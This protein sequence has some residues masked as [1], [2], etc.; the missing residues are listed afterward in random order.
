MIEFTLY[1]ED[2]EG[3]RRIAVVPSQIVYYA[4]VAKR[5]LD[6]S[7]TQCTKITLVTGES[8]VVTACYDDVK[9]RLRD[10]SL[11][12]RDAPLPEPEPSRASEGV[13]CRGSE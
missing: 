10:Y 2:R 4:A 7:W 8:F 3:D 1:Q 11:T 12:G 9:K 5:R 13:S 6:G